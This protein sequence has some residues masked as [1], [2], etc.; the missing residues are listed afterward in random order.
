[1]RLINLLKVFFVFFIV[2]NLFAC[3]DNEGSTIAGNSS[4]SPKVK[5]VTIGQVSGDDR[6]LIVISQAVFGADSSAITGATIAI[7]VNGTVRYAAFDAAQFFV[8][9]T[10]S[11]RFVISEIQSGDEVRIIINKNTD[12]TEEYVG[13]ASDQDNVNAVIEGLPESDSDSVSTNESTPIEPDSG[14]TQ[15][16]I[17]DAIERLDAPKCWKRGA[18][19][20]AL[21]LELW[22]SPDCDNCLE[23]IIGVEQEFADDDDTIDGGYTIISCT[24]DLL[25]LGIDAGGLTGTISFVDED[26]LRY[27]ITNIGQDLTF[28]ASEDCPMT[29]QSLGS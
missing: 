18:T 9:S 5:T 25:A 21:S 16:C 8:S 3:G 11:V 19:G 20:S 12:V 14:T 22:F 4:E 28:D 6:S 23:G 29:P 7:N 27:Q 2:M 1:M 15:D 13:M 24:L 26:T 10:N 17:A